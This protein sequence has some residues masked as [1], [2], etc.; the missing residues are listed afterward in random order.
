MNVYPAQFS[1]MVALPA[2]ITLLLR[3]PSWFQMASSPVVSAPAVY[4]LWLRIVAL[5]CMQAAG[6]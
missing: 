2:G 4:M 3:Y 1:L 5:R 6:G